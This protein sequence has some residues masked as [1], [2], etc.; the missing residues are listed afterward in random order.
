MRAAFMSS[1][2]GLQSLLILK[3]PVPVRQLA[4]H[5]DNAQGP[6]VR[7][8]VNHLA[9]ASR[10][11]LTLSA[12]LRPAVSITMCSRFHGSYSRAATSCHVGSINPSMSATLFS[13]RCRCCLGSEQMISTSMHSAPDRSATSVQESRGN[14]NRIHRVGDHGSTEAEIVLCNGVADSIAQVVERLVYHAGISDGLLNRVDAQIRP[15]Q[16]ISQ[17]LSYRSFPGPREAAEDNENWSHSSDRTRSCVFSIGEDF[18]RSRR[19]HRQRAL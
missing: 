15:T 17:F 1:Y 11:S 14:L 6:D 3:P 12:T 4:Q 2:S 16:V 9:K 19:R 7:D 18:A 8:R 10:S 13:T 5:R